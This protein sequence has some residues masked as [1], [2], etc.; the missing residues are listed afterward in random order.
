MHVLQ[1]MHW[2]ASHLSLLSFTVVLMHPS[3][4]P[5][6]V[7]HN[8]ACSLALQLGMSKDNMIL[9]FVVIDVPTRFCCKCL[10]PSSLKRILQHADRSDLQ[11]LV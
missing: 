3:G 11:Q 6:F 4:H 8:S 5:V 10:K 2:C 7:S 1:R 9:L